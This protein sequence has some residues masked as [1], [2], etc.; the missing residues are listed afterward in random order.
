M[1]PSLQILFLY[2]LLSN[3][4]IPTKSSVYN[5]IALQFH[6]LSCAW[7]LPWISNHPGPIVNGLNFFSPQPKMCVCVWRAREHM[8]LYTASESCKA[9]LVA[10]HQIPSHQALSLG[11]GERT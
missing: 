3:T 8:C 5:S 9:I 1:C 2:R 10:K 4:Q 11:P 6:L 7:N